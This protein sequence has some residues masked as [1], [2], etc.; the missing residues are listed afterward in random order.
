AQE[1]IY[2]LELAEGSKTWR[3]PQGPQ[4]IERV[5]ETI[6]VRDQEPVKVELAFTSLAPVISKAPDQRRA[7]VIRSAMLEPGAVLNL[8]YV[9]KTLARNWTEFRK[10]IRYAVW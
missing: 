4:P 2:V 3:G 10:A 1:G 7:L 9:P 6:D 8:E 5:V